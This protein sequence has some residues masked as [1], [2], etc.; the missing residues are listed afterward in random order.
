[1]HHSFITRYISTP[2]RLK[3]Y[4]LDNKDYYTMFKPVVLKP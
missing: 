1:M 4:Q 3:T 2:T